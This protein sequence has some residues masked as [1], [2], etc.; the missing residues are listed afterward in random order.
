MVYQPDD[1]V[2]EDVRAHPR[3][4]TARTVADAGTSAIRS[5]E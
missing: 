5:S 1:I 3:N 2:D 4:L